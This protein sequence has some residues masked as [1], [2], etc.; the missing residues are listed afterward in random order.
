MNTWDLDIRADKHSDS[1]VSTHTWAQITEYP[2]HSPPYHQ[3]HIFTLSHPYFLLRKSYRAKQILY[4]SRAN[5]HLWVSSVQLWQC[6][7]C[8]IESSR[9]CSILEVVMFNCNLSRQPRAT[10]FWSTILP[11]QKWK[12]SMNL[13]KN[14]WTASASQLVL[15]GR[16]KNWASFLS[17]APPPPDS[18]GFRKYAH[19]WGNG[20]RPERE[21]CPPAKVVIL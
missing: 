11:H 13:C 1:F 12:V 3:S 7:L 6:C 5:T 4:S 20:N 8:Q 10:N 16:K 14:N 15:I 18:Y 9:V 2:I 19:K 21:T 17:R